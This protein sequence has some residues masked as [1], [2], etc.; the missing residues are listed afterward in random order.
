MSHVQRYAI[1]HLPD[2]AELAA[3]GAAWLG[4]NIETGIE[5]R[6]PDVPGIAAATARPRKYGFHATLKPPFRLAENCDASGL[7]ADTRK[8][9]AGMAPVQLEGMRVASLGRFLALV[10]EGETGGLG[11]LAFASVRM[12]DRYRR[13]A[14]AEELA[15]RRAAGLT[16]RQDELLRRWGYPFVGE[17]F[18]FHLTL[19]GGL[20]QSELSQLARAAEVHLPELPR[21]YVISSIALVGEGE[22]GRFRLLD[23]F[24]LGG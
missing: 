17:E 16:D 22:D 6:Q 18:R 5:V 24:V 12:L 10:P 2:N 19:S 1:Y 7:L 20:P 8:L 21:P 15:R 14:D 9:A 4:W 13:P 3:F 11:D 23:R